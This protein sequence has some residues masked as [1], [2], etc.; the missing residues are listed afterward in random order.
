MALHDGVSVRG[1]PR[2]LV[3]VPGRLTI[4][5]RWARAPGAQAQCRPPRVAVAR[6]LRDN[7]A[8]LDPNMLERGTATALVRDRLAPDRCYLIS[9]GHVVAPDGL[10]RYDDVVRIQDAAEDIDLQGR[11]REWQPAMVVGAAAT[12]LDAALVEVD[13]ST[14]LSLRK[15]DQGLWLP[16]GVSDE[17][18]RDMAVTLQRHDGP[19]EGALKVRWSGP[20]RVGD[21]GEHTEYFLS[22]ALGYTTTGAATR[23]GDSG[24]PLWTTDDALLGMHIAA[25]D[26]DGAF[27][28]NAVMG[29][30]TPVLDWFCVKP[31]TRGDPAT[32]SPEETVARVDAPPHDMAPLSDR[33]G[34]AIFA[35][36]LW[37][38]ARGEG[39]AGMEAVAWVIMN[40][41]NTGYRRQRSVA[42]VCQDPQQFSCWNADDPN[43]RELDRLGSRFDPDYVLALQI[44]EQALRREVPSHDARLPLPG[45]VSGG[46]RHYVAS[47]LKARP[48]WLNGKTP[49]VVIGHHEFYN[50]IA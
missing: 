7:L 42:G 8:P 38:E 44:A 32:V 36:T 15:L 5:L 29:R 49:F 50:D 13:A 4:P 48:P 30:I 26:P 6:P 27:G 17:I 1:L 11:L 12:A 47:S 14:V 16:Q 3:L 40:R 18:R 24:A 23:A 46:S 10:A 2:S 33:A 39:K 19:L 45:D 41:L 35:K 25:I 28:A 37:G 20:V 21:D 43:R 34:L 22:E 31:F 9:C